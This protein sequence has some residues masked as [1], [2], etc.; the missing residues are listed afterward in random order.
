MGTPPAG[1]NP[2]V[3]R[4]SHPWVAD[5]IRRT[6]R[7]RSRLAQPDQEASSASAQPATAA[8]TSAPASNLNGTGPAPSDSDDDQSMFGFLPH[9]YRRR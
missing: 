5:N 6:T 2:S 4:F 9:I 3:S 1:E 7:R 8:G